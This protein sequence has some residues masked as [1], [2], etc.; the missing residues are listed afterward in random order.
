MANEDS[1]SDK[2]STSFHIKEKSDNE[3]EDGNAALKPLE[4]SESSNNL[5]DVVKVHQQN[6][7]NLE[8]QLDVVAQDAKVNIMIANGNPPEHYT[9]G[10]GRLIELYR[11]FRKF[12]N[13]KK[14]IGPEILDKY[15]REAGF[16]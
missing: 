7:R 16:Q 14:D 15:F 10:R 3:S 2:S 9:T 8:Q 5:G 6:F 12:I 11:E 1:V 13:E 4:E